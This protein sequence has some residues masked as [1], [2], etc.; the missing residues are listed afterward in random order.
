M[1]NSFCLFLIEDIV[2]RERTGR[3]EGGWWSVCCNPLTSHKLSAN[4][5]QNPRMYK[6]KI[7]YYIIFKI[8][9]FRLT[10]FYTTFTKI[11]KFMNLNHHLLLEMNF[12]MNP[13]VHLLVGWSASPSSVGLY[14]LK[15]LEVTLQCFYRSSTCSI[16]YFMDLK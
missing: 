10:E 1:S 4:R 16:L 3:M 12:P 2:D 11:E 5:N 9:F 6:Q 8:L 15:W 14:F 13:H 7:R